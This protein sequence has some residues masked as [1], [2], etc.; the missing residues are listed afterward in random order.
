MREQV[1]IARLWLKWS[2]WLW[3]SSL[4][5]HDSGSE[6]KSLCPTTNVCLRQ[7]GPII[8]RPSKCD[9]KKGTAWDKLNGESYLS[10][11]FSDFFSASAFLSGAAFL[12]VAFLGTGSF[13]ILSISLRHYSSA[14]PPTS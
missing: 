4:S 10:D 1:N 3:M 6:N 2:A 9:E 7:S 5:N 12:S 11:F 14:M 8:A 13:S